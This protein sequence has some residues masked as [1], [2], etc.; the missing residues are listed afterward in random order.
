MHDSA[1]GQVSNL[2]G[3]N[4]KSVLRCCRINHGDAVSISEATGRL[5]EKESCDALGAAS[6][7]TRSKTTS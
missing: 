1:V 3:Q 2:T 7:R 6:L 4:R 5:S